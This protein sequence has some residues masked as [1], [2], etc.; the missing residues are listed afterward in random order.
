MKMLVVF[1]RHTPP[2]YHV[3]DNFVNTFK[4][5]FT[6][7]LKYLYFNMNNNNYHLDNEI[8]YH[9]KNHYYLQRSC[10]FN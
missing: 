8:D 1:V 9:F 10:K 6:N 2:P 4:Q 7:N 3:S 5:V